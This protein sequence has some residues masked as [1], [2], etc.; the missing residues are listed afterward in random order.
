ML[1][2]ASDTRAVFWVLQYYVLTAAC[3]LQ[4]AARPLAA[5][6]LAGGLLLLLQIAVLCYYAFAVACVTHNALHTRT[7]R[8]EAVERAYHQV[9]TVAYGHVVSSF[10][11]GHVLSHHRHTQTRLDP[12]RT[13]KMTWRLHVLNLLLFHATVAPDV[14]ALDV[15]YTL[16][17]RAQ[18][19][20]F[21]AR[22]CWEWCAL[23]LS[24]GAL[25]LWDWRSFGL[26]VFAPHVFAQWGIVTMNMLQHDGCDTQGADDAR[27]R[28]SA[29]RN[30]TGALLNF[31]TFNNG[32]HTI[33]HLF[34]SMH[35]SRLP[36]EHAKI[37][38]RIPPALLQASMPAYLFAT[39]VWP[40]RRTHYLGGAV[41]LAPATP[42][43]LR[44]GEDWTT[45]HAPAAKQ[46]SCAD[47]GQTP[48][49]PALGVGI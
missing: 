29:S 32:L 45:A 43:G 33:H 26:F 7:F 30:F 16:Q 28:Y 20:G 2:H 1:L 23:L 35:W 17:Q 6:T 12:M 13:S 14:L 19:G 15:R 42:A 38:H 41:D 37:Q 46:G 44:E 24:Q 47:P 49:P 36:A 39:F 8:S 18:P 27:A 3:W 11:P 10:M 22:A 21:W 34:P 31:L 4:H 48:L 25:L 40:G 5:P 9:L